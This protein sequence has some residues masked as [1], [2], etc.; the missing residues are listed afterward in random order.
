MS[1]R[2]SQPASS[3]TPAASKPPM[4]LM[5]GIIDLYRNNQL[6]LYSA[7]LCEER[8]IFIFCQFPKN[9]EEKIRNI[10]EKENQK[11]HYSTS[12]LGLKNS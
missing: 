3:S 9:E 11:C 8:L 10:N 4:D 12:F 2:G 5:V 6:I 1:R 7:D